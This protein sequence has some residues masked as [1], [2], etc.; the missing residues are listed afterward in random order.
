[1][2]KLLISVILLFSINLFGNSV[3]DYSKFLKTLK[4]KDVTSISK[5]ISYF[6]NL[7]DVS[8][9]DIDTCYYLFY[10]FYEKAVKN[11][12]DA[13]LSISQMSD[14]PYQGKIYQL[15][16]P[17]YKKTL[18]TA[19]KKQ[20]AYAD[21]LRNNGIKGCYEDGYYCLSKNEKFVTDK[22]KD[23]VSL[24]LKEYLIQT[25]K[26]S[27]EGYTDPEIGLEI[28]PKK[29]AE[30]V[31][32]WEKFINK[33][34]NF[35]SIDKIQKTIKSYQITLLISAG[36]MSDIQYPVYD[37]ETKKLNDTFKEAYKLII[38]QSTT[39]FGKMVKKYYSILQ[40]NNFLI[41]KESINFSSEFS[42]EIKEHYSQSDY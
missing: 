42:P 9:K 30:R 14:N 24:E 25:Q 21:L 34:N 23:K 16:Q 20:I 37:Y 10:E 22:L 31:I 17:D 2:N 1:M 26:E 40:K 29:L 6:D 13:F 36:G 39:D 4:E 18:K 35:P 41:T 11:A 5:A 3:E 15:L 27:E 28:T 7:K 38:E 8:S 12:N 19:N 33:Y 32:F